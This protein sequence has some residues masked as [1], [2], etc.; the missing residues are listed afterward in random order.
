MFAPIVKP[1]LLTVVGF[2]LAEV[3]S[4]TGHPYVSP[5]EELKL[6]PRRLR[7]MPESADRMPYANPTALASGGFPDGSSSLPRMTRAKPGGWRRGTCGAGRAEGA[8]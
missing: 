8:P 1:V 4:I 3:P 2:H 5:Y 6:K 7:P